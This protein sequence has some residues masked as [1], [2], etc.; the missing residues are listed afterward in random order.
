MVRLAE[1]TLIS[2]QNLDILEF[3]KCINQLHSDAFSTITVQ[4][5][6]DIRSDTIFISVLNIKITHW[7]WILPQIATKINNLTF[8]FFLKSINSL[9][10]VKNTCWNF[11]VKP[12]LLQQP[13]ETKLLISVASVRG[14]KF[15]LYFQL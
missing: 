14:Q 1:N 2:H 3:I 9:L 8:D 13:P 12:W 5:S 4:T 6:I 10:V 7:S 11:F 15:S